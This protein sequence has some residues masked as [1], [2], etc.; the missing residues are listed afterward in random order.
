M[1]CKNCGAD[2][3]SKGVCE[4]CDT[5]YFEEFPG[6]TVQ[7]KGELPKQENN[8]PKKSDKL[9]EKITLPTKI[10]LLLWFLVCLISVPEKISSAGYFP[11]AV[12]VIIGFLFWGGVTQL[13]S[14]IYIKRHEPVEGKKPKTKITRA[15]KIVVVLWLLC[16]I[17]VFLISET[18][19]SNYQIAVAAIFGCL[20][21]GGIAQL[22]S[23]GKRKSDNSNRTYLTAASQPGTVLPQPPYDTMDACE[24]KMFCCSILEKNGFTG[25]SV[26]K[27]PANQGI[28]LI[29]FKNGTKYGIQCKCGSSAVGVTAVQKAL[30]GKAF[31][32]CQAVAILTNQ[33]FSQNAR[34]LAEKNDIMLWNRDKLNRFIEYS[35][36][37]KAGSDHE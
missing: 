3:G 27:A 36:I 9:W 19:M 12:A 29:A 15:T 4:Y 31:F 33:F 8:P 11:C 25:I 28:D 18:P 23:T 17:I 2:I 30:D 14:S 32:E 10:A 37:Q 26:A 21:Y 6:Q 7:G 13:I 5:V 16:C 20:I 22:I 35:Q 24:F 1:I 34:D